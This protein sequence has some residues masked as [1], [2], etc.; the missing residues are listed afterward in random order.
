MF[1]RCH[2]IRDETDYDAFMEDYRITAFTGVL[3]MIVLSIEDS[4]K[5]FSE[6]GKVRINF[7]NPYDKNNN[8]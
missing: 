7:I 5:I 8:D 2:Y 1:P 4:K 6:S 3:E